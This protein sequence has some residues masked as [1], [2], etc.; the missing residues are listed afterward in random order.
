MHPALTSGLADGGNYNED[1]SIRCT[2]PDP[3]T[4]LFLRL[5]S[6]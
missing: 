5:R 4:S 2:P 1:N 6:A 3:S